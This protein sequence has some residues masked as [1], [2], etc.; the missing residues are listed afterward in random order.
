MECSQIYKCATWTK[1]Q[2]FAYIYIK[3]ARV[4]VAVPRAA[5]I[6]TWELGSQTQFKRPTMPL[7]F[8]RKPNSI[9]R[10]VPVEWGRA[11]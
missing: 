9:S 11:T 10:L 7:V 1:K 5:T 6:F 3:L 4:E 8:D 2:I